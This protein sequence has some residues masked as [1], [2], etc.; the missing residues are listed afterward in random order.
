M[1]ILV[2]NNGVVHA[3]LRTLSFSNYFDTVYYIDIKG[4]DSFEDFKNTNI[5]Y[6]NPF[7]DKR[8]KFADFKIQRLIKHLKPD[9]IVCHYASGVGL[10]NAIMYGKCTVAA[11][12]MGHDVLYDKG[13]GYIQGYQ[14]FLTRASLHMCDYISAKSLAIKI[15]LEEY[16]VKA[17]IKIN[18]WGTNIITSFQEDKLK[19]REI[20]RL[21]KNDKI[22]LCP[23]A[24]EPRLNILL[25]LE[26]FIDVLEKLP[27]LKLIIIGR[28][29]KEYRIKVNQFILN[30]KLSSRIYIIDECKYEILS[31]Y[32][33]ASDAVIS[34]A[35]SDGFPNCLLEAMSFRRPVI[36]GNIP[37]IKELLI[38]GENAKICDLN[39]NS[40]AEAIYE[41]FNQVQ[42][43]ENFIALNAYNLVTRVGD[44]KINGL[45]FAHDFI[46]IIKERTPSFKKSF[47]VFLYI[48]KYL[49]V[50]F[51]RKSGSFRLM[52]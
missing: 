5:Q 46:K 22:L 8:Y 32:Y 21:N 25:L 2:F 1:K 35:S 23:R 3:K 34:V 16:G 11:I 12:A 49:M 28:S 17:S 37:Q 13:D 48:I 42:Y 6:I 20:L 45:N 43:H 24:I 47:M 19:S 10:Y 18:Y 30:N 15:R 7:P 31:H 38:N 29:F 40:I 39:R 9:G 26:S 14:K 33:N 4:I 52:P 50:F 41:V 44:I 27:D 51:V 36:A